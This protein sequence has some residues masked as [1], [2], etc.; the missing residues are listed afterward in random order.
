MYLGP[1]PDLSMPDFLFMTEHVIRSEIIPM[2]KNEQMMRFERDTVV[3]S[4][5]VQKALSRARE[6]YST[7]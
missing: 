5:P 7:V 4:N 2:K 3:F 1:E 6:R